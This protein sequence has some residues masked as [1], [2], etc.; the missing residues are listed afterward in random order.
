MA[1]PENGRPP[2]DVLARLDALQT[3]DVDWH[4]G[5]A[6]SLAY[7][8]GDDV[9]AVGKEAH[10]RYLSTNALNP[11]AFPS[12]RTLQGEVVGA[13]ADLLHGGSEAGGFVTTGGTESLLLAVKAAR[14]R[15]QENE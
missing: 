9:L 12:L 7:H 13:V 6:F 10:A 15:G 8:A 11:A 3:L 2:D 4:G 5:R 1:L 14:S